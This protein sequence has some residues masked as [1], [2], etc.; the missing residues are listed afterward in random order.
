MRAAF[1]IEGPMPSLNEY[2]AAERSNRY[3]GSRMKRR[4]TERARLAAVSQGMPHF[5]GPVT[6]RFLW[7]ERNRRRDLDNVAFAKKFILDGLVS[8][9][10]LDGDG[11]RFVVGL[12]DVFEHDPTR[13]RVF[14]E[15]RDA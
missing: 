14:V 2:V 6:V 10:V 11:Q 1:T 13:P 12:L 15:V 5:V 3:L 8:A 7:V 9:G 4:E